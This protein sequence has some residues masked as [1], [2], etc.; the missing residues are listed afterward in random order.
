MPSDW[1]PS[2]PKRKLKSASRFPY[3]RRYK[4]Q[5]SVRTAIYNAPISTAP[6]DKLCRAFSLVALILPDEDDEDDM[7]NNPDK[8]YL[9]CVKAGRDF[10]H[11][12]LS[13]ELQMYGIIGWEEFELVSN[14]L[15]CRYHDMTQN[16]Y[17]QSE[18]LSGD[19][20]FYA[21]CFRS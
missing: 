17:R 3:G 1:W 8:D 11:E 12:M 15:S 10:F 5:N 14:F 2:N 18:K 16:W 13:K 7:F 6:E 20:V 4:V 19:I 21:N 9:A